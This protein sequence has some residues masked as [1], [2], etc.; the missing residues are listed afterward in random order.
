MD[1]ETIKQY[2]EAFANSDP[3]Q[4]AQIRA[5]LERQYAECVV[6]E[7]ARK[8]VSDIGPMLANGTSGSVKGDAKSLFAGGHSSA[9]QAGGSGSLGEE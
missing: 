2:Q 9:G 8:V 4:Q 5:K 3:E 6:K 1:A 7:N